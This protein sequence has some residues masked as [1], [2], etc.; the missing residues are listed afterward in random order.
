MLM[1]DEAF[2]AQPRNGILNRC[3]PES[4]WVHDGKTRENGSGLGSLAGFLGMVASVRLALSRTS[5]SFTHSLHLCH[6]LSSR[7]YVPE[8]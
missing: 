5:L 6:V 2:L 1:V 4:G 8:S 7:A 3:L